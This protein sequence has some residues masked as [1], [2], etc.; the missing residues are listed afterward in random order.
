MSISAVKGILWVAVAIAVTMFFAASSTAFDRHE[1]LALALGAA[2]VAIVTTLWYRRAMPA[3]EAR[4]EARQADQLATLKQQ[5]ALTRE[6]IAV[7]ASSGVLFLT[8][9]VCI[10]VFCAGTAFARPGV[11]SILALA[12]SLFVT[13]GL[14]LIYV[15]RIGKPALTIRADGIDVPVVGFF[16]W[17]E[18]ESIGLRAHTSR[19]AT[20]HTLDLYVPRLRDRENRLHPLQRLARRAFLRGG[21][22]FVVIQLLH[23]SL[24]PALVHTLCYDL[25]KQATGRNKTWTSAISANHI[26]DMRRG[27]QQLEALKRIGDLAQTDPVE[28][29]K[30]LEELQQ[31][32]PAAKPPPQKPPNPAAAKRRDALLAD[33]RTIDARD[34]AA[35]NR[36]LQKHATAYARQFTTKLVIVAVTLVALAA[37]AAYFSS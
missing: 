35:T 30:R 28:A 2:V 34:G 7:Q 3:A 23:P 18:I 27:D 32:F 4:E 9:L 21:G 24:P 8:L 5:L 31:R 10:T 17:D 14:G 16:G 13:V 11:G 26:Q 6:P 29:M 12:F 1:S 15:P 20:T 33:L 19:G 22:D 25:W 36:V 37:L